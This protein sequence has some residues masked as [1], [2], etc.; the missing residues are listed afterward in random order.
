VRFTGPGVLDVTD[1]RQKESITVHLVNLSN[2]M[3]MKG[4]L[5]ELIPIGEQKVRVRLPAGRKAKKIQLLAAGK[6]PHV[7]A[8]GS[9]LEI[10]VPSILDHE[11]VAIDL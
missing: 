5:R 11:V 1:W 3:M 6:T 10:I 8:D 2:P 7:Q 9:H 4:P